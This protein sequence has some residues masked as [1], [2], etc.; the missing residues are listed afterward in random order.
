MANTFTFYESRLCC[1]EEKGLSPLASPT[2]PLVAASAAA[3]SREKEERLDRNL[4][5]CLYPLG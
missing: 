5:A 1:L 3:L 2:L 4:E